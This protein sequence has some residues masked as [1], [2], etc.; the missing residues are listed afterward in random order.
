MQC[1]DI[2]HCSLFNIFS[3]VHRYLNGNAITVVEGLE[4][5][6]NLTELH[7]AQQRLPEGEKLLFDP[8]TIQVLAVRQKM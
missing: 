1:L 8:R 7:V 6:K 3:N 4:T 5:L 2:L